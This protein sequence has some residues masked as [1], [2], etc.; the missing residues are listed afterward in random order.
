MSDRHQRVESLLRE[1]VAEY[2]SVEANSTPLITITQVS[3]SPDYRQAT[4]YF[5]TIPEDREQDALIFM[6]RAGGDLRGHVMKK[7]DLK[8]I[9]NF[10]FSVDGGERARQYLD[11]IA[12]KIK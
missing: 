9:P 8:F 1:L 10:T 11:T 6:Q 5:T 3:V 12:S 4:V 2:V 7:S